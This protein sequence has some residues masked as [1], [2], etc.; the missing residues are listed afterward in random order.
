MEAAAARRPRARWSRMRPDGRPPIR[1]SS[2]RKKA[3]TLYASIDGSIRAT[4]ASSNAVTAPGPQVH[5]RHG[6]GEPLETLSDPL[7]VASRPLGPDRRCEPTPPEADRLA[8]M[9]VQ[10]PAVHVVL[11]DEMADRLPEV[12]DIHGQV[13]QVRRVGPVPDRDQRGD[14]HARHALRAEPLPV[15]GRDLPHG[16]LV[17]LQA[18][19]AVDRDKVTAGTIPLIAVQNH[20]PPG[21][22]NTM[23]SVFMSCTVCSSR[24][25]LGGQ[26]KARR[27]M[28]AP[29]D[30]RVKRRAWNV[31][32][33]A[34][35][36]EEAS[37]VPGADPDQGSIWIES[38]IAWSSA[39]CWGTSLR[40]PWPGPRSG[41]HPHR[42]SRGAIGGPVPGRNPGF[43]GEVQGGA[44]GDVRRKLKV[45]VLPRISAKRDG[46]GICRV[47]ERMI[48]Q[49]I[50][51][52]VDARPD[53]DVGWRTVG[54]R[55]LCGSQTGIAM[56]PAAP[57]V[58]HGCPGRR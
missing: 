34:S 25:P 56:Q 29:T 15:K 49:C 17:R 57:A 46:D 19:L 43:P 20:S 24:L 26:T 18:K 31:R 5:R 51:E 21:P 27:L 47:E 23:P 16:R 13:G 55:V 8:A 39:W 14:P 40:S 36:P 28:P 53:R 3:S 6:V 58:A 9:L 1:S 10:D 44:P 48:G 41:R 42:G 50:G 7:C 38:T 32:R 4:Y 45:D 30:L 2:A 37:L 54:G 33:L 11:P 35:S 12:V 52:V 22:M